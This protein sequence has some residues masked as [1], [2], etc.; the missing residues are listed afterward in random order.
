MKKT[1]LLALIILAAIS[2]FTSCRTSEIV[3]ASL[4]DAKNVRIGVMTGSTGEAITIA[5]FPKAQVKSFDDIMDA[6]AAMKSGQID[7][8][9]TAYPAALQVW[10]WGCCPSRWLTR[11]PRLLSRKAMTSYWPR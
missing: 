9:V 4:D 1:A 7:A 6:V 3:I 10:N 2:F 11:T 5:R 8:I